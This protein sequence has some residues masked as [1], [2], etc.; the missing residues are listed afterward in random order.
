MQPGEKVSFEGDG[1][2]NGGEDS[3]EADVD[4]SEYGSGSGSGEERSWEDVSRQQT[5]G[6]GGV[7]AGAG[8]KVGG[9]DALGERLR[10][11][12]TVRTPGEVW[13]S[14]VVKVVERRR[15]EAERWRE[16]AL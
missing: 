4:T 9:V 3:G 8:A 7:G 11:R 16:W 12:R 14:E 2:G 6:A 15:K 13:G 10:K 5:E 1:K